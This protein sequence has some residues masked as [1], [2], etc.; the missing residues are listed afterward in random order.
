VDAY[1]LVMIHKKLIK[2]IES[3]FLS[4]ANNI[5]KINA[6]MNVFL[7]NNFFENFV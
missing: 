2:A 1:E 4:M 3:L 5:A 7:S 6:L